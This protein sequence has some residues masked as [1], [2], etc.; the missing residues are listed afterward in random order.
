MQQFIGD[1]R[2]IHPHAA[3]IEHTQNRGTLPQSVGNTA[4]DLLSLRRNRELLERP[5]MRRVM[6]EPLT[7]QPL[8]Q[9]AQKVLVRELAAPQRVIR[10]PG[11]RETPIQIEQPYQTRPLPAPI[12]HRQNRTPV[13]VQPR[14]HVMAVLPN[15]LHHNNR[16]IRRNPRKHI[17]PA[18][19]AV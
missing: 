4:P 7:R 12:R 5:H 19:L 13:P 2:V 15:S 1:D 8:L 16:R 6:L 18:P 10:D 14:Q 9:P 17:Q 3:L 11:L